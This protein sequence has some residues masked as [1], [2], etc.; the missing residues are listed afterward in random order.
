M[1][2]VR[3]QPST[4]PGWGS[5]LAL[6]AIVAY[7]DEEL[8]P[9]AR[10][11]AL[12][13]LARC[14]ECAS[15]VVA[16]TQARLALRGSAAPSLPSALLSSLRA[17]PTETEL[18]GPPAGLAVTSE[19]QLVSVLREPSEPRRRHR[20][21]RLGAGAVVTGLALGG[22][23]VAGGAAGGPSGGTDAVVGTASIGGTAYLGVTSPAVSGARGANQNGGP[24]RSIAQVEPTL[25]A[26]V[27]GGT[28]RSASGVAGRSGPATSSP[29]TPPATPTPSLWTA[30]R[31]RH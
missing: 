21:V 3:G 5:H 27:R 13:H 15:E 16:Q 23:M 17:I 7:V 10:R 20:G 1:T 9:A 6:D 11:R 22:L 24:S 25:D 30:R 18:P 4:G 19:G 8:S 12:E 14:P 31:A 2:Q 26:K 29:S 28:S